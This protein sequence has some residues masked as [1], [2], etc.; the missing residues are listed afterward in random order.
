MG[1]GT[2]SP[3]AA[4]LEDGVSLDLL[5]SSSRCVTGVSARLCKIKR[6]VFPR[7][8]CRSQAEMGFVKGFAGEGGRK[9]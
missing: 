3:L 1:G 9:L 5:V 2:G 8:A 4:N 7:E 6:V